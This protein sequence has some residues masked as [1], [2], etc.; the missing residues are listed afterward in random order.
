M[1]CNHCAVCASFQIYAVKENSRYLPTIF[2]IFGVMKVSHQ[3]RPNIV[4]GGIEE[5]EIL[6]TTATMI[7]LLDCPIQFIDRT[8]TIK[9]NVNQQPT[10]YVYG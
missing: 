6:I 2:K 4:E 3:Q 10:C 1:K 9:L 8:T 5:T 7:L